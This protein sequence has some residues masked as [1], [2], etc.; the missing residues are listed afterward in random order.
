AGAARAI[1]LTR[2]SPEPD[3]YKPVVLWI[4]QS[5]VY[6]LPAGAVE[7]AQEILEA[8]GGRDPF[9][10]LGVA[11]LGGARALTRPRGP[12]EELRRCAAALCDPGVGER[13]LEL[14]ALSGWFAAEAARRDGDDAAADRAVGEALRD[15]EK[16][17]HVWLQLALLTL[18]GRI[19]PDEGGSRRVD[20]LVGRTAAGLAAKEDREQLLRAWHPS[21]EGD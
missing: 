20:A 21:G 7:S 4:T 6:G 2:K 12:S 15:A 19:R 17:D 18:R 1:E 16:L 8:R 10:A 13:H 5:S 3:N 9:G 14:R 11:L